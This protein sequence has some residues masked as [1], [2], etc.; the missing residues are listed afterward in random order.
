MRFVIELLVD[1]EE[2][3]VV[4]G[5]L[6]PSEDSELE[7]FNEMLEAQEYL[8]TRRTEERGIFPVKGRL[9]YNRINIGVALNSFDLYKVNLGLS[10]EVYISSK[11]VYYPEDLKVTFPMYFKKL[12]RKEIK[13]IEL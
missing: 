13:Q 11:A 2:N 9:I 3:R 4:C 10:T 7:V 8:N 12:A 1:I 5:Y 6:E